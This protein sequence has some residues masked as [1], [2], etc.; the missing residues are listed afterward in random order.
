MDRIA[1]SQHYVK[2]TNYTFRA[3]KT[4]ALIGCLM[5]QPHDSQIGWQLLTRNIENLTIVAADNGYD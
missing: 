4:T 1:A 2:W 3:V 5:K